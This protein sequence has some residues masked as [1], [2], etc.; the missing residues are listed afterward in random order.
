MQP[1][2]FDDVP[3]NPS[4]G[5][6]YTIRVRA[7]MAR[8][9]API[10]LEENIHEALGVS[11]HSVWVSTFEADDTRLFYRVNV[12]GKMHRQVILWLIAN[13]FEVIEDE[14]A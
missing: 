14:K 8:K 1:M 4:P 2:P 5:A 3:Y 6:W 10:L 9:P 13:G 7:G 12:V 11:D